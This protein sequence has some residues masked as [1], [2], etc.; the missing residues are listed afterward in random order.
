MQFIEPAVLTEDVR[1][2][3][4]V[5]AVIADKTALLRQ[6]RIGRDDH[7]AVPVR[8]QI[9][10]RVETKGG[11]TP[12]SATSAPV[13]IAAMSLSGILEDLWGNARDFLQPCRHSIKVHRNYRFR[14]S[15][16]PLEARCGIDIEIIQRYIGKNRLCTDLRDRHCGSRCADRRHDNLIAALH[17]KRA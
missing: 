10:G 16:S 11:C 13:G 5:L 9:L 8:P 15:R 4:L 12:E 2:M 3:I 14:T 17:T 1:R 7:P 6:P